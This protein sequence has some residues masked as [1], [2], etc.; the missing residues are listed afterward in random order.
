MEIWL[1]YFDNHRCLPQSEYS[2]CMWTCSKHKS[3][4]QRYGNLI[5]LWGAVFTA[6]SG[7][8][9]LFWLRMTSV[10][11]EIFLSSFPVFVGEFRLEISS[12]F[13]KIFLLFF[14]CCDVISIWRLHCN[15]KIEKICIILLLYAGFS[16][17]SRVCGSLR[18]TP[19]FGTRGLFLCTLWYQRRPQCAMFQAPLL[20]RAFHPLL[21]QC[22]LPPDWRLRQQVGAHRPAR[23]WIIKFSVNIGR[24]YRVQ[25]FTENAFSW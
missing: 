23:Y 11:V 22:L 10:I 20:W 16:S 6:C 17:G 24:K 25:S 7:T 8:F 2:K 9:T 15:S 5:E 14:F 4:M 1:K 13:D 3:H 21:P 12:F 18:A 19:G